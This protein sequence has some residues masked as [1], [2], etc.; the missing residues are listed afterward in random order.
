MKIS[1][2]NLL[3]QKDIHELNRPLKKYEC[4]LSNQLEQ[5]EQVYP[6]TAK[7]AEQIYTV[8]TMRIISEYCSRND[9]MIV[10]TLKEAMLEKRNNGIKALSVREA[11]IATRSR[12]LDNN[13]VLFSLMN[14]CLLTEGIIGSAGSGYELRRRYNR[15]IEWL[16]VNRN[17]SEQN[18]EKASNILADIVLQMNRIGLL[19]WPEEKDGFHNS[20]LRPEYMT[21][22]QYA[23]V[24]RKVIFEP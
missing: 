19:M 10:D 9:F 21:E 14:G 4:N 3:H 17:A 8:K 23:R 5:I 18:I 15:G 24:T 7:A 13:G 16:K 11:D 22:D 12:C 6:F 2:D 1:T 20:L